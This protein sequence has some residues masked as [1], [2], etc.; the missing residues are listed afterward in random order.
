MN[1]AQLKH[2]KR[3]MRRRVLT[4]R[5]AIPPLER[6]RLGATIAE[7]FLSLPDVEAAR[8]VM[9]FWAFGSEVPTEPIVDALSAGGARVALPRV[10]TGELEA[11]EFRSGD[12]VSLT[13]FGAFEPVGGA[14][15]QPTEIDVVLVPAVAFDRDCRRIGYGGGYYDRFLPRTRP[16][17]ARVG[18]GFGVQLLPLGQSVPS[19]HFDLP[20]DLVITESETARC[21]WGI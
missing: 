5:D 20:V 4:V 10:V 12:D 13:Q 7:R 3:D 2:A 9:A 14:V 15:V 17:A 19:G 8:T 1:S 6:A 18:I 21:R 16:D 11:R